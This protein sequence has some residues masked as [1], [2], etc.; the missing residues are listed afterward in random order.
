MVA[1]SIYEHEPKLCNETFRSRFLFDQRTFLKLNSLVTK[2]RNKIH[3][4]ALWTWFLFVAL[5]FFIQRI[6]NMFKVQQVIEWTSLYLLLVTVIKK[7]YCKYRKI[8]VIVPLLFVRKVVICTKSTFT[9]SII[10]LNNN[11]KDVI[12]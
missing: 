8:N 11:G 9:L 10:K 2:V 7:K 1:T 3:L 5:L 4:G 6:K 12:F